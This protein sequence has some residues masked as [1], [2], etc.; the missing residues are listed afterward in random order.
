MTTVNPTLASRL[1]PATSSSWIRPVLL[2]ILG[3]FIVAA[4]AQINVPMQ[5]VPMTLQTL[6]VLGIGASYGARLGAATLALYLLEGCVGLPVFAEFSHII[7][8]DGQVVFSLGFLLGFIPAA[9]LVGWLVEKG[10][11]RNMGTMLVAT[12]LAAAV[13]YI[14]G[15]LWLGYLFGAE[16]AIP[17]GLAP[18]WLGDIIKAVIVALGVPSAWALLGR[19]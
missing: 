4:A 2:C 12:L 10:W 14:P 17:Y 19:N 5:P 13:L 8:A 7:R 11:D 9:G 3:T 15:I 16:N 1:W 18:F 6:A